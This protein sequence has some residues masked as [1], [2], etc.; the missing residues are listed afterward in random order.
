MLAISTCSYCGSCES[1]VN[2]VPFKNCDTFKEFPEFWAHSLSE[3]FYERA[4]NMTNPLICMKHFEL[5]CFKDDWSLKDDSVPLKVDEE[6]NQVYNNY[7]NDHMYWKQTATPN[8]GPTSNLNSV[9]LICHLCGQKMYK[10]SVIKHAQSH[11]MSFFECFDT[12]SCEH[13][14][15]TTFNKSMKC[16]NCRV[17]DDREAKNRI[18]YLVGRC[19]PLYECDL[20]VVLN[21]EDYKVTL[22]TKQQSKYLNDRA[23]R[24]NSTPETYEEAL[25]E[26]AKRFREMSEYENQAKRSRTDSPGYESNSDEEQEIDLDSEDLPDEPST[27]E[28]N[29]SKLSV[30]VRNMLLSSYTFEENEKYFERDEQNIESFSCDLY[31]NFSEYQ[32]T[33][34]FLNDFYLENNHPTIEDIIKISNTVGRKYSA[35]VRYLQKRRRTDQVLCYPD[36]ICNRIIN[37]KRREQAKMQQISVIEGLKKIA[38]VRAFLKTYKNEIEGTEIS[39]AYVHL[40]SDKTNTHPRFVRN[41]VRFNFDIPILPPSIGFMDHRRYSDLGRNTKITKTMLVRLN[42][43]YKKCPNL[44]AEKIREL[45]YHYHCDDSLIINWFEHRRKVGDNFIEFWKKPKFAPVNTLKID[46]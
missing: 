46:D 40:I 25:I 32:E 44:S 14:Q 12:K 38:G 1:D 19:F 27:S 20:K 45:C 2:M 37:L 3:E 29:E 6:T 4:R 13:S 16:S 23:L 28:T 30:Y 18:V 35:V 22:T 5:E 11:D 34:Q 8:F 21:K 15:S 26:A 36:D 17:S 10:V 9:Q 7:F 43:E 39:R 24:W 41:T 31:K 42:E 33:T